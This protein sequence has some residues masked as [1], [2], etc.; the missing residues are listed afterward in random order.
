MLSKLDP[1]RENK[2]TASD[3][4]VICDSSADGDAKRT[5]LFEVKVG[6]RPAP[7][8]SNDW[9]VQLGSFLE[10][11][12]V[13]WHERRTGKELTER[14]RFVMHPTLRDISCTLDCFR[15]ADSTVIDAKVCTGWR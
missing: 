1:R 6:L 14:Q 12:V 7:D 2:I 8:L 13:D 3:V 10:T 9:P 5:E 15:P 4:P 11:F